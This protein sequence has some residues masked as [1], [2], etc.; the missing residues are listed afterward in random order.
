MSVTGTYI[1]D[2]ILAEYTDEAVERA[3]LDLQEITGQHLIS[4]RRSVG[5]VLARWANKG[6]RQWTF[7]Q[8]DHLVSV[9]EIEFDLPVGTIQVQ[10]AV[11]RR[12]TGQGAIVVTDTEM[13]PISRS[14]YLII[15]DKNLV[16]RPDRYFV[17][18][19]RDT[20]SGANPV[21]VLYWLAA[22]NNTD[23]IIMNVWKQIQDPGRAQNTIDI[24]FRYQEAF[25]AALA[26]KVA[27]KWKPERF[28][29]L[30]TESEVLFKEADDEDADTAPMVIS[31][32]YD[33][34][35]GR[36]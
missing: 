34:F 7:E 25:V 26:A 30:V 8:V 1:T 2:P 12:G 36:R 6:G 33:R 24:P 22:E 35:Y 11:L 10:T 31:V 28:V 5:F 3:G 18:R 21:R 19:R 17:D 13:Y 27:Q 32:N 20:P 9:G 29:A 16:G 15:H 23:R 4:I 14:D